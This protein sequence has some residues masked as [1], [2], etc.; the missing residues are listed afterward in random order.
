MPKRITD[1][2]SRI[3]KR[4][5]GQGNVYQRPGSRNWWLAYSVGGKQIRESSKSAERADAEALLERRLAEA[6]LG[7]RTGTPVRV[8]VL[9]ESLAQAYEVEGRTSLRQLRSR[10]ALHLIPAFG[11]RKA[12]DL[13]GDDFSRYRARRG[14][15]GAAAATVN[16][17]LEHLR[18]ALK[19][20]VEDGTLHR[21][22][23]IRM[24]PETNVRER[25]LEEAE[26]RRLGETLRSRYGYLWPLFVVA[27]HTGCRMG[28]LRALLWSQVDWA[29]GQVRLED[30]QTK[31]G[32]PRTL[33][34]YGEMRAA[35]RAALEH[36]DEYWPECEWVFARAGKPL[37]DCRKAWKTACRLAGVEG[38]RFHDLRRSAAVVMDRAG[39]SRDQIMQIM[40]HETS[41]MFSRYRI[42]SDR[43][44]RE[45]GKQ[46][47]RYLEREAS[48]R[49]VEEP[50]VVN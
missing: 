13:T 2:G 32:R 39:L 31:S 40:G 36:R 5:R 33:P 3:T 27:Y 20:A 12:E 6:T 28:E 15:Q 35:L 23:H 34:I 10:M 8:E 50:E 21:S 29:A 17:E 16:R 37:G 41:A 4:P 49:G 18:T 1:H 47:E 11:R 19:R 30:R 42:V 38:L 44:I 48:R 7:I 45:A 22:P 26:Y 24:S 46:V 9:L 14:R 25:F 43:E